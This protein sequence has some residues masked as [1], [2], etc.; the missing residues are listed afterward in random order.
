MSVVDSY[1]HNGYGVTLAIYGGGAHAIAAWGFDYSQVNNDP[2]AYTGI[3][4]TD[5]DDHKD[6][7]QRYDILKNNGAWYLRDYNFSQNW[8]IGGV[9]A[10]DRNPIPEPGTIVLL[11]SG[12]IG[13]V[14][15]GRNKLNG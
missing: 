12:L 6:G 9:M 5:S 14:A 8:Y 15:L 13:L 11:G 4:I 7:L 3:W 2:Y 1:L 10:L